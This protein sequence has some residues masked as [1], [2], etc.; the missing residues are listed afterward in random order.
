MPIFHWQSLCGQV[1]SGASTGPRRQQ[2]TSLFSGRAGLGGKQLD[3]AQPKVIASKN[4]KEYDTIGG[5]AF[6]AAYSP[7]LSSHRHSFD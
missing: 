6:S 3:L 7:L 5:A 2:A 1:H 4:G